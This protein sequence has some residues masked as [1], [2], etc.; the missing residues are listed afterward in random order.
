[1]KELGK[2]FAGR[3]F[4]RGFDFGTT[5]EQL[6][7]HLSQ[8]GKIVNIRWV[9]KGAAEVVYKTKAEAQAAAAQLNK[10][11]IEGNTRFID[12]LLKDSE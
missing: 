9:S 11:I 7:S 1:M 4:V 8:A 2:I 5:D 3:V 10:S 6:E 12:V